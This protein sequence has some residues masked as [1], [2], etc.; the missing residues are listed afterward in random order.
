MLSIF[1]VSC[2]LMGYVDLLDNLIFNNYNTTISMKTHYLCGQLLEFV[3][4]FFKYIYLHNLTII[5]LSELDLECVILYLKSS[6]VL[7]DHK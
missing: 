2:V 6:A 5:H 4:F 7:K 3:N 1:R